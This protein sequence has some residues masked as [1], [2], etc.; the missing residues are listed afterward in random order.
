M[1]AIIFK[2]IFSMQEMQIDNNVWSDNKRNTENSC[3]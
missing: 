1:L 2:I 3:F